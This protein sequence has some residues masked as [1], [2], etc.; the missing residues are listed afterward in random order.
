MG[1]IPE[2]PSGYETRFSFRKTIIIIIQC[3]Q[4]YYKLSVAVIVVMTIQSR[5]WPSF[6]SEAPVRPQWIRPPAPL[7]A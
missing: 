5:D 7:Y 4:Y 1:P 3:T 6:C 2:P